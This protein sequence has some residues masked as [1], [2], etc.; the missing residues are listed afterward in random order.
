MIKQSDPGARRPPACASAALRS[1]AFHGT[2]DSSH[3][4]HRIGFIALAAAPAGAKCLV[5][6]QWE[7]LKLKVMQA[8]GKPEVALW[9]TRQ[10]GRHCCEVRSE[11][12]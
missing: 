10:L 8:R 12:Q 1:P 4:I 5:M 7:E 6:C 3:R 2:T 9:T 11:K